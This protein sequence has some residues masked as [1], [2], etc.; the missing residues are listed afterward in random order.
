MSGQAA[1][2]ILSAG[3]EGLLSDGRG[4]EDAG[5]GQLEGDVR[6]DCKLAGSLLPDLQTYYFLSTIVLW[7]SKKKKIGYRGFKIESFF[8]KYKFNTN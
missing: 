1:L 5:G 4:R 7:N 2:R 3:L 6:T 8:L